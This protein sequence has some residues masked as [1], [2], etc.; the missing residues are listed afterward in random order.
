MNIVQSIKM[1][2]QLHHHT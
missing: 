2:T 1:L